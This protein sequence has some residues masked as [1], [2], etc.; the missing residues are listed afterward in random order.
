MV[1]RMKA[2][3]LLMVLLS[4]A[5]ACAKADEPELVPR[6][7][8]KRTYEDFKASIRSFPYTASPER[9]DRLVA[10]YSKVDVGMTKEDIARVIGDPDYSELGYGPKGPNMK[11]QGSSWMYY[12]SKR[13]D[14]VNILDPSVQ[15]FFDREDRAVWIVPSNIE[16]LAAK[17]SPSPPGR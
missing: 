6:L 14:L 13:G 9:R 1:V 17:G 5:P 7:D 3:T 2:A 11:W 16:G 12:L 10:G 8:G 15:I 4:A